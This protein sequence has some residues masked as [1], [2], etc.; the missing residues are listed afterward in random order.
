MD[1]SLEDKKMKLNTISKRLV[2]QISILLISFSSMLLIANLVLLNPLY[3]LN[4]QNSMTENAN[5]F[6]LLDYDSDTWI[7]EISSVSIHQTYDL[8]ITEND[9]IVYSSSRRFGL[10]SPG[11]DIKHDKPPHPSDPRKFP[12]DD[13]QTWKTI[14]PTMRFGELLSPEGI[15][16]IYVVQ[17]DLGNNRILYL[18]QPA[19]PIRESVQTANMLLGIFTGIFLLVGIVVSYKMS[20][21]FTKPIRDMKTHLHTL[22]QLEFGSTLTIET[23]DELTDLSQDINTLSEELQFALDRLTKQNIQLEKDIEFQRRFLSNAS[24]ELRTPLSLIKG[25]SDEIFHGFIKDKD[26]EKQYLG[27][28]VE[29]SNK[30][31][32]LLNE[33][34]E[35]SRLESGY[36]ELKKQKASVKSVIKSFTE[37]YAGFIEDSQM[38][39]TLD[40]DETKG[41]FDLVRFEQIL[42]NL[43][44]NAAKYSDSNKA[45]R[46]SSSQA[47]SLNREVIRVTISNSGAGLTESEITKI[48]SAFYKVDEART[49]DESS[50]GLGLSIVKAIQEKSGL[51]YGC[52]CADN[53][54]SFWFDVEVG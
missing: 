6:A 38:N 1:I 35:L 2:F 10:M 54:V 50:Y 20:T 7:S 46:I 18:T 27:F 15:V 9:E 19:E 47:K 23:N 4:T 14:D 43:L 13:V 11:Q 39:L 26:Q 53:W 5:Q 37:K 22:S 34:L 42:A 8:L 24:H 3:K 44:S 40:L 31:N 48:W 45:V 25:Y 52:Y 49:Y 29:E 41:F 21:N 51:E 33:L 28:I 12:L 16:D 36:L 32:R 17:S 30:M